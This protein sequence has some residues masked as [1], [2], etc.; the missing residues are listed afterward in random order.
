MTKN[1]TTIADSDIEGQWVYGMYLLTYGLF[2]DVISSSDYSAE[3]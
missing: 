1:N 3:C 2:I